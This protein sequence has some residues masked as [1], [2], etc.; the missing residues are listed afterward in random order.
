M[1]T[2]QRLLSEALRRSCAYLD[3]L[4]ERPVAP[5]PK[6]L[7]ALERLDE[8]LPPGTGDPGETLA[9]LDELVSPA[10]MSMAGPRFF[11][12]VIGGS[13]PVSLAA[14]WLAGAWDQNAGFY[15]S[16]PGVSRLEQV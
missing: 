6:A 3:S 8:A 5:R 7:V 13:L 1:N 10:T 16:T 4:S 14:N 12:F 11:G 2:S 9:L 15:S